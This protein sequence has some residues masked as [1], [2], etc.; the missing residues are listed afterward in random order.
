MCPPAHHAPAA[1]G[2]PA[3]RATRALYNSGGSSLEAAM[4]WLE[5]HEVGLV[6][7]LAGQ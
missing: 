6:C 1:Q 2:F 3:A 4:G 7:R 5:E